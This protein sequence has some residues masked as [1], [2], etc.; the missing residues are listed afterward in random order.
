MRWS[1]FGSIALFLVCLFALLLREV[2]A[3]GAADYDDAAVAALKLSAKESDVHGPNS[4]YAGGTVTVSCTYDYKNTGSGGALP[5]MDVRLYII[6]TTGVPLVFH[7]QKSCLILKDWCT[8]QASLPPVGLGKVTLGCKIDQQGTNHLD[9]ANPGNNKAEV[10][11]MMVARPMEA[12]KAESTAIASPTQPRSPW[13]SAGKPGGGSATPIEPKGLPDIT[14]QGGVI[15]GGTGASWG[16]TIGVDAKQA[17]SINANN[18]GLC[19]FVIEHTARNAGL[20][21]TGTFDSQWKNSAVPGSAGRV[22]LPLA[23]GASKSEKDLVRLKPG[24]N[25]LQLSLDN[26]NQV[27]ESNEAN[28]QFGLT[29]NVSGS[30][31]PVRAVVPPPSDSQRSAPATQ[32][33]PAVPQPSAEPRRSTPPAR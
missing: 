23:A 16:G 5:W 31:G 21:P 17:L 25:P 13:A 4:F 2:P 32:R 22:W 9:D 18:S 12:P 3:P 28:N 33:V 27:K 14:S 19:E 10:T 11:T 1:R 8:A 24:A 26:Q 15:V 7:S 20:S 6:S 29:V 30:C